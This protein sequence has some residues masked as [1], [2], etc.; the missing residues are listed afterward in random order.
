MRVISHQEDKQTYE[1]RGWVGEKRKIWNVKMFW[2]SQNLLTRSRN[3]C[4][5]Q[6]KENQLGITKKNN[7]HNQKLTK[8]MVGDW[9][10]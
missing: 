10:Q 1:N 9:V 6:Q 2:K 5:K 4:F 8:I 3:H 7:E